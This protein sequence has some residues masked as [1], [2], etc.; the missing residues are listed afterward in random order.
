[1]P[2]KPLKKL[3][4]VASEERRTAGDTTLSVALSRNLLP[5]SAFPGFIELVGLTME[6]A[7]E[8]VVTVDLPGFDAGTSDALTGAGTGVAE[9]VVMGVGGAGLGAGL[10]AGAGAGAGAGC[11]P[12]GS[13]AFGGFGITGAGLFGLG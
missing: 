12:A 3:L 2:I 9:G 6:P 7:V 8:V 13:S 5:A 4:D 10:G 11:L 1:M